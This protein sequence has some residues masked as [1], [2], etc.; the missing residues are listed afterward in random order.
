MVVSIQGAV[1]FKKECSICF[2]ELEENWGLVHAHPDNSIHAGYCRKC[3]RKFYED[4]NR[5]DQNGCPQCRRPI[6]NFI[7][8]FI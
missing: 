6:M 7:K 2:D 1:T 4:R 8:I 5:P 3:A